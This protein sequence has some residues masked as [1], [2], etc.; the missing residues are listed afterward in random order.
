MEAAKRYFQGEFFLAALRTFA[1]LREIKS[2]ESFLDDLQMQLRQL[3]PI[4]FARRVDH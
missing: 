3:F 2:S 4:D 1:P